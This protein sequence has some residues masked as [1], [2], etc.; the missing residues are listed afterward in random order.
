MRRLSQILSRRRIITSRTLDLFL[1][2]DLATIVIYDCGSEHFVKIKPWAITDTFSELECEDYIR[3]FQVVPGVQNINLQNAGQFKDEVLDFMI[4]RNVPVKQLQLEAANLVSD[5]KWVEYFKKCGHRLETLKLS[6]LDNSMDD[7]VF[8]ALVF[9]C[10]NLRRLKVKKCFKL[11]SATLGPMAKLKSLE[12]L[13]LCFNVPIPAH[14]LAELIFVIGPSL[15][16]LSLESFSDADDDVLAAVR[17]HCSR[18][19]K[20][21]FTENDYC[22]DAGFVALFTEWPNPPLTMIDLSSTRSIDYATPDGPEE[23]VGLA[24]AGFNAMMTHSGS[25]IE[26]LDIS[27]CRHIGYDS[28]SSKFNGIL[29]N[30][31]LKEIN[32]SFLPKIDTSIIAGMLKSCPQL[33]RITA[34][35]CFNVTDI[36]VPRGIALIGLPHSQDLLLQQGD[37]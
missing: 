25:G 5:A 23:A 17:S 35:G 15:R 26:R 9:H 33:S 37:F 34:F 30:P 10:P 16:T 12:H 19:R 18:L 22:T 31:S 29:Q 11:T 8:Y 32:I 27:S 4:E 1:R 24:S 36:A 6:W 13:S 14:M 2:S 3:L 20:L 7:D 28:F 21:R